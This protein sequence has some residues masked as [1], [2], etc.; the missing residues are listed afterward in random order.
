[1]LALSYLAQGDSISSTTSLLDYTNSSAFSAMFKR[2]LGKTPQSF[3][4]NNSE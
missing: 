2:H 1:M 3:S 4:N